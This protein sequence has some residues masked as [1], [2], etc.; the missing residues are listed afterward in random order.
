MCSS[1][2]TRNDNVTSYSLSDLDVIPVATYQVEPVY[3]ADLK[4]AGVSGR[5]TVSC[6]VDAKG[7]VNSVRPVDSTD[8]R[9]EAAAL[10]AVGKW[11]FQP[12]VRDG[13]AVP[14]LVVVPFTFNLSNR[15]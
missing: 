11:K 14:S 4:R 2:L 10:N 1:D 9:F 13:E 12:G 8:T 15:Y 5:A 3:P 6:V 7:N